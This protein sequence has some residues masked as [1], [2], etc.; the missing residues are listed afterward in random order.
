MCMV[1]SLGQR[2]FYWRF[3]AQFRPKKTWFQP[4]LRIFHGEKT[5]P[6][7]WMRTRGPR[8]DGDGRLS[9]ETLERR[10]AVVGA[11]I[12]QFCAICHVS[13]MAFTVIP[14]FSRSPP[15]S[16]FLL[17]PSP[18]PGPKTPKPRTLL[19]KHSR[20][21]VFFHATF[22]AEFGSRGIRVNEPPFVLFV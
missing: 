7:F 13:E 10:V 5:W 11:A 17:T 18:A 2:F 22:D 21:L 12:S 4:P 8:V 3:F 6:K 19:K 20:F 9:D 15:C 16:V 1:L 14:L